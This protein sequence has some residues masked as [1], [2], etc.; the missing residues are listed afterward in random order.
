MSSYD[1]RLESMNRLTSHTGR[2]IVTLFNS[3]KKGF[4]TQIAQDILPI[5]YSLLKA[6]DKQTKLDLLIYS[7]GGQIDT[8]WP[9]VNLLREYCE[10]LYVSI[11]F[12]AHSAATLI[13]LGAN[14][15]HMGP[16]AQLSPI[17]P[18]VQVKAH[19]GKETISTGV[20]DIYGY[21]SL[22]KDTLELDASGKTEALKVLATRIGPEILGKV[23]RTRKEIRVIATNLLKLH[24]DDEEKI[25]NI[26]QKLVEDLPSHQYM[27]NRRE[28]KELGLP[29]IFMDSDNETLAFDILNS[30]IQETGMEDPGIRI[31]FGQGE[32]KKDIELKRAFI[33]TTKRSFAYVTKYTATLDGKFEPKEGSWREV[34]PQ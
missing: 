28:A 27:I 12:R 20:E 5:F 23:S 9:F 15:V 21:Y 6:T 11:P 33:E 14:E 13:A 7:A 24:M 26:V 18:Q 19:E 4:G 10:Q 22:V 8:P 1:S 32:K 17:D 34:T 2:Q 25:E 16:L 29:I 3:T 30:Y 31:D